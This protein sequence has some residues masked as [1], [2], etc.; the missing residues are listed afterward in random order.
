MFI[1]FLFLLF[2]VSVASAEELELSLLLL[3][4]GFSLATIVS[5][6]TGFQQLRKAKHEP[7]S[8]LLNLRDCSNALSKQSISMQDND[9]T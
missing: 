3:A 1:F 7:V 4:D 9:P 6:V 2:L 8:H 5:V